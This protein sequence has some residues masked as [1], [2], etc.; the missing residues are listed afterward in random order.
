MPPQNANAGDQA[1]RD[2]Q[3]YRSLLDL[4][5]KEN[6]IK[7]TKLQALLAVNAGLVVA[8][9]LARGM[10]ADTWPISLAGSVFSWIWT[11][12]IGRTSLFQDVWEL[13]I[14][15]L[16]RRYPDDARFSVLETRDERRRARPMLRIAGAVPSRW[17]LVLSPPAIALAWL[18]VLVLSLSR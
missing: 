18:V 16:R 3:L 6:P 7:T 14:A 1:D 15:D 10:L 12:S 5:S 13:K 9:C 17:Y 4:W 2:Y 8:F 11:F